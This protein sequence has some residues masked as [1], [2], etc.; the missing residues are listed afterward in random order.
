M[1]HPFFKDINWEKLYNKKVTPPYLPKIKSE[2]DMKLIPKDMIDKGIE[3]SSMDDND[4]KAGNMLGQ[5]FENFTYTKDQLLEVCP[6][7]TEI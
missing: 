5:T 6:R 7:E 3:G 2:T 4:F 1:S